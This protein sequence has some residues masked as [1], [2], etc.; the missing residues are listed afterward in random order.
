MTSVERDTPEECSTVKCHDPATM[1][2]RIEKDYDSVTG[3]TKTTTIEQRYC[4]YH[5]EMWLG[6]DGIAGSRFEVVDG[7]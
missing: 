1:T 4:E 5:A 2:L 7:E 6:L 3:E